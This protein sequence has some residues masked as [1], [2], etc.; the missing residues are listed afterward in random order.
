MGKR[1]GRRAK[2]PARIKDLGARTRTARA[3][4]A[5]LRDLA[6]KKGATV[7][8]GLPAVQKVREAATVQ[9]DRPTE[10]VAFYYNKIS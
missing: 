5:G 7:R 6:T 3:A 2:A 9:P 10:E 4:H 1:S 8:G